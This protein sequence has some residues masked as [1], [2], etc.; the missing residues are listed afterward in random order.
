MTPT[1]GRIIAATNDPY[2]TDDDD[3]LAYHAANM[4]RGRMAGQLRIR[5]RYRRF[6]D[7]WFDYLMVSKR[8]MEN[9]LIGTGWHFK[10]HIDSARALYI[11][12]IEKD[13]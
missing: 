2:K 11:A 3:H 7:R 9:I 13:V 12:I 4:R 6:M 1:N 5:V 10:A 8:K